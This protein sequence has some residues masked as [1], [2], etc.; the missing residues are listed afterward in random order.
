MGKLRYAFAT[1]EKKGLDDVISGVFGRAKTFTIL[2]INNQNI[3][4]VRILDNNASKYHHG[5]GPLAVKMLA[6]NDV[7]HVFSNK[8]GLGA[9]ELL[10]QQNIRHTSVKPNTKV[11]NILQTNI[12]FQI[13]NLKN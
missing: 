8:I 10:K 5:A 4:D 3:T 12:D 7:T 1:N 9:S 2:D 11:S 6:D 13:K